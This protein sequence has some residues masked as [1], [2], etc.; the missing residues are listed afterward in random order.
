MPK[1]KILRF[2]LAMIFFTIISKSLGIILN[3]LS[4]FSIL[5]VAW[6]LIGIAFCIVLIRLIN[7]QAH[8]GRKLVILFCF[9]LWV[10]WIVHLWTPEHRYI[11]SFIPL[12]IAGAL[13]FLVSIAMVGYI[14]NAFRSDEMKAYFS[15][16]T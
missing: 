10:S 1:P 7:N 11:M 2:T 3:M 15:S 8:S 4:S 5:L 9:F 12:R 13:E 14:V 6:Y 16:K